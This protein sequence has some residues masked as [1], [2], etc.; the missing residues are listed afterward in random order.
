[1]SKKKTDGSPC[2]LVICEDPETGEVVVKPKGNCPRGYIE[3]LRD[4]VQ[5]AGKLVWY[6][7]KEHE[8]RELPAE[9]RDHI[10]P[11]VRTV[12]E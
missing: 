1:M 11:T 8:T 12:E 4:K 6:V 7:P 3:K 10:H 5:K 9:E 2:D